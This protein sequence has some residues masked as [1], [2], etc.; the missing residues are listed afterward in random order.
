MQPLYIDSSTSNALV[1][2]TLSYQLR[3]AARSELRKQSTIIDVEA[4]QRE[5]DKAFQALSDLLGDDEYFFG[6]TRPGLFDASV[7]AYTNVLLDNGLAWKDRRMHEGLEGCQ[8]L[9]AH[10]RRIVE[11]YFR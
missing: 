2:L 10:R 6:E 3:A 5:S 8:N 7:F 4:V 9:V 1:R 11:A